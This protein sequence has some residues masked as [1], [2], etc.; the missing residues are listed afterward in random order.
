MTIRHLPVE[1]GAVRCVG[2][3]ARL[4][5]EAALIP[6]PQ[7]KEPREMFASIGSLLKGVAYGAACMYIFDPERGRRRRARIRDQMVGLV[8]DFEDLWHKGS[9]DLSNRALGVLAETKRGLESGPVDDTL[10]VERVRAVLGHY[11][12]NAHHIEV[13]AKGG[14]VTLRGVLRPGEPERAIPAIERIPGVRDVESALTTEGT[15]AP[16]PIEVRSMRPGTRLLLTAGGGLLLLNGVMRRGFMPTLLGSV[17]A[18][19]FA[20]NLA[21]HRSRTRGGSRRRPI[22]CRASM[23]IA[24]PIEKVYEFVSDVE[25]SDRFL[26]EFVDIESLGDGRVRWSCCGPGGLGTLECEE[27][28]LEALENERLVWASTDSSP[29]RYLGEARFRRGER[30]T[31][32]LDVG[33]LYVPPGG[34]IKGA[35]ASFLG[36]DPQAELNASLARIKNDLE[37]GAIPEPV[38]AEATRKQHG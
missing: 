25:Q 8:H 9:R 2:S 38:A 5:V 12:G 1:S 3:A 19:V 23:T 26:P 17:G 7:I 34:V 10:L 31:T 33:L 35:V 36:L 6:S 22:E 30:D 14:L 21:Q 27:V 11:V 16:A 18:G 13:D 28:V 32:R 4:A 20:Q 15:P 29:V 24:A 37:A